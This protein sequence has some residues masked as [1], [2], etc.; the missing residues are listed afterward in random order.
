MQVP[1]HSFCV[2]GQVPPQVPEAQVAVPPVMVGQGVQEE[3]QLAGSV[4]L[5]HLPL[6][7]Q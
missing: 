1:L 7:A 6:P 5:R 2:L 4:S 3:P